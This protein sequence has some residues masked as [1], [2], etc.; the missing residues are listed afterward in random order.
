MDQ[1]LICHEYPPRHDGID[2]DLLRKE[3]SKIQGYPNQNTAFAP[4][5]DWVISA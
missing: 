2:C 1:T 5:T 4:F 3:A